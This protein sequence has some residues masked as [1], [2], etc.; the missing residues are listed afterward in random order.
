[1]DSKMGIIIGIVI[2][3]I[4][5]AGLFFFTQTATGP[6]TIFN[7]PVP[8]LSSAKLKASFDAT[9]QSAADGTYTYTFSYDNNSTTTNYA[10]TKLNSKTKVKWARQNKEII[11]FVSKTPDNYSSYAGGN[12][13]CVC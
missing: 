2:I 6:V 8:P 7:P 5:G 12:G 1:M 4:V 10:P 9:T 13:E 3:V 11:F